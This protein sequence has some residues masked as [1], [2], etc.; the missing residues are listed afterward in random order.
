MSD[1]NALCLSRYLYGRKYTEHALRKRKCSH[2]YPSYCGLPSK[3]GPYT[4]HKFSCEP[5]FQGVNT[6]V[7]E[8]TICKIWKR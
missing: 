5:S 4:E 7:T 6:A 1:F 8:W 3:T 2:I